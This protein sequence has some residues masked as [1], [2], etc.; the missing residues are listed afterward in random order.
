MMRRRNW[1]VALLQWAVQQGGR[2]YA[3]GETDCVTL[4]LA[5][6]G[7]LY[8]APPP[9]PRFPSKLAALR[10]LAEAPD[11]IPATLAAAGAV[12]LALGFAG[13]GDLLVPPSDLDEAAVLV[14]LGGSALVSDPGLGVSRVPTLALPADTIAWRL[15][16]G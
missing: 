2:P 11:L 15:P 6:V 1:D 7:V 16:H 8:P 10:A 5:A 14:C 13:A 9:L 4:A 12:P 3:W